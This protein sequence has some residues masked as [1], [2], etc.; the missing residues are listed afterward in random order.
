M[1]SILIY[2]LML[3]ML[4]L[5]WVVYHTPLAPAPHTIA[6]IAL[7]V[8]MYSLVVA[9]FRVQRNQSESAA[10]RPVARVEKATKRR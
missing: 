10:Q 2:L 6:T 5:R 4:S 1:M 7:I 8:G 3:V 9:W